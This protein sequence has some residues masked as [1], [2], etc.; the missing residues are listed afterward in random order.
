MKN[1][2]TTEM[3][4]CYG[5]QFQLSHIGHHSRH[6]RRFKFARTVS[7]LSNFH[8]KHKSRYVNQYVAGCLRCQQL[9]DTNERKLNDPMSLEISERRWGSLSSDFIFQ[10]TRTKN[11][12]DAITTWVDRLTRRVLPLKSKMAD[13]E[14]VVADSFFANFFKLHGLPENIV[15]D[16][17][18]KFTS[19]FWKRLMQLVSI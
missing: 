17:D 12:Y 11:G 7:R 6:I 3:F 8:C 2:C 4:V 9:K 18:P 19:D 13:T 14:I 16:R 1:S 5:N 10:F 15:S